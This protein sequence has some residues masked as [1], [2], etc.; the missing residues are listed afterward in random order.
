MTKKQKKK[1]HV[2][3]N[4]FMLLWRD[5]R[6]A[7]AGLTFKV[8]HDV[9]PALWV[10]AGADEREDRDLLHLLFVS[11]RGGKRRTYACVTLEEKTESARQNIIN[12]QRDGDFFPLLVSTGGPRSKQHV[13][14]YF[15][16]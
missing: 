9:F 7:V 12:M 5:S 13:L 1:K 16:P 15:F 6:L 8:A 10:E 11:C 4:D 14:L 2:R 3:F